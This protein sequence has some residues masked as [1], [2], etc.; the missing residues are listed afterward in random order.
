MIY[1]FYKPGQSFLVKHPVSL[2]EDSFARY[3]DEV[4]FLP[5]VGARSAE[6]LS[7]GDS[8]FFYNFSYFT[9]PVFC[10]EAVSRGALL[11]NR[12]GFVG[13]VAKA[14]VLWD[15]GVPS[16]RFVCLPAGVVD[17][18]SF[19]DFR[20][21]LI[22]KPASGSCGGR[23]II[24]V[25]SLD[26]LPR[27]VAREMILQEYVP[28]GRNG[29]VRINV[30]DG[31]A[32]LSMKVSPVNNNP[33]VNLS[34]TGELSAYSAS[35]DEVAV[36]VRAAGL[37]GLDIAGV[38]LVQGAD[39]PVVIEVNAVPGFASAKMLGVDFPSLL[40]DLIVKRAR[41]HWVDTVSSL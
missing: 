30:V 26:K 7:A 41:A 31:A 2:F 19:A 25:P 39:G 4:C 14:N 29:I 1:F 27:R 21:P 28:E 6:L 24:Y 36:S 32:A 10:D 37:I 40:V 13:K 3:D 18:G 16:P 8:V 15:A 11:V 38:D 22:V 34:T 17:R 33:V 23:N 12:P 9:Q 5:Y 35:D 20:F